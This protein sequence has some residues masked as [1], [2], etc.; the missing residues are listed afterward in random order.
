[1]EES[2]IL[3]HCEHS[4]EHGSGTGKAETGWVC[5]P[6]GSLL[7]LYPSASIFR[8]TKLTTPSS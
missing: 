5:W 2:A 4:S 8:L 7:S 3:N 6:K 1:M